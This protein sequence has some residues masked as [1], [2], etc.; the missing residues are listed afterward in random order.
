MNPVITPTQMVRWMKPTFADMYKIEYETMIPRLSRVMDLGIPSD[1]E[2]EFYG[3]RETAPY[4]Q[5]WEAGKNI[6]S[7]NFKGVSFSVTNYFWAKR[8]PWL[9]EDRLNDKLK[10][11]LSDVAE[12]GRHWATLPERLLF[13]VLTGTTDPE[14]LPAIPLAPDGASMFATTA[15]GSARFGVTGGNIVAGSGVSTSEAVRLNFYQATSQQRRFL[16]TQAQPLLPDT[17][18]NEGYTVMYNANND[19]AFRRAF[20][21]GRTIESQSTSETPAGAA[22]TNVILDAG[23]RVTLWPTV[24]ITDNDWFIALNGVSQKALFEQ[25]RQALQEDYAFFDNSDHVRDTREE[26]AQWMSYGSVGV[27]V[28]YAMMKVNN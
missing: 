23:I 15:G 12:A 14:L 4:P 25:T 22:V 3:Y 19:Y 2:T 24:R 11:L 6:P 5:L 21:Q 13:Q 28:P 8:V 20:Q 27:R 7:G 18:Y 17:A 16:N 10:S 26:Y 9:Y 1:S